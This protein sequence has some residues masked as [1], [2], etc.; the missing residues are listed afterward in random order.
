[1]TTTKFYNIRDLLSPAP[2]G[3]RMVPISRATLYRM[4]A[5][6]TFPKPRKLGKR[7]V[8][9]AEDIEQWSKQ[10]NASYDD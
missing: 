8:W 9:S 6:G 1:M 2:D 7:S 4:A 3:A 5:A 10:L